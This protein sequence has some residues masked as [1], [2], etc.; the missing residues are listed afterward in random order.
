LI[1]EANW[2]I[3]SNERMLE[4]SFEPSFKA[5]DRII[6]SIMGAGEV[7]DIDRDQAVYVIKFD[8]LETQRKISFKVKL[9]PC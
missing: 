5:G 1:N 9:V 3:A 4:T 8:D 7:V 2:N 6:H